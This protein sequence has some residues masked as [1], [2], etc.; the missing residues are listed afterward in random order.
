MTNFDEELDLLEKHVRAARQDSLDTHDKML[1]QAETVARS[2]GV[3]STE[4][5][6]IILTAPITKH[7]HPT[8]RTLI[9]SALLIT[10]PLDIGIGVL[11][12][13]RIQDNK[14]AS[15]PHFTQVGSIPADEN[16]PV[17]VD[18]ELGEG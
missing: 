2:T 5:G 3:I 8:M 4:H 6:P 10:I 11:I 17:W 7:R 16:P 13:D 14:A 18:P 1:F 9:A 12:A 15:E